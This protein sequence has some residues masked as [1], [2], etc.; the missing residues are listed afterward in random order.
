M[1][2]LV[3]IYFFLALILNANYA[4]I[5]FGKEGYQLF[6]EGQFNLAK[7]KFT[8]QINNSTDDDRYYG[9]YYRGF[10]EYELGNINEARS[11]LNFALKIPENNEWHNWIKSNS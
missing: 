8:L 11:D 3:F 5:D 9:Y 2:R 6:S 7:E 1:K 10:C 4:Q